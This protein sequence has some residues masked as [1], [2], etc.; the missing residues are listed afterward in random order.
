MT[1]TAKRAVRKKSYL[2]RIVTSWQIYVLMLPGILFFILF[3]LMPVW[4]LGIAFVDFKMKKGLLGSNFV[5]FK[6]FQQFL[7]STNAAGIFRNTLAIS[8]MD[9]LIG[10]PVPII[11]ALLF[12]EVRHPRYKKLVQSVVYMPHFMSW[13]VIVGITFFLFSTDVGLVNKMIMATGGEAVPFLTTPDGFWW[14]LVLQNIW[15]DMGWNT[16][17]Y[18]AAV[19][20][21][22]LGLYEAATVDGANRFQRILHVTIPCI[23]PTIIVM[24]IMRLGK[25]MNVNFDQVWMMGN[26][27]VRSVSETFETYAFRMGIQ[28][29]N[30][31]V[32]TAVGIIKSLVGLVLVVTSNKVIKMTGNDGMY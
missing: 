9:L 19:S 13:A 11:L 26:D 14:V 24:F 1:N 20:Q 27:M 2:H 10:F 23:V 31:S 25:M 17:I 7:T 16:I 29:G 4:G 22:D 32:G 21:V 12:N 28:Q 3:K 6:Y 15:K 18:L 8:L 5:G 30:Y